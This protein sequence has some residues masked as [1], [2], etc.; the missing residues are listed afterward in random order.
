MAVRWSRWLGTLLTVPALVAACTSAPEAPA[1][2]PTPTPAVTASP[3]P[4]D[5][6]L[7]VGIVLP[8]AEARSAPEIERVREDLE[9]L[10]RTRR[11]DV[12]TWR[13]L[14][15]DGEVFVAD[16]VGFLAGDGADLVCAVGPGAREV[17]LAVAPAYP[18]TRFCAT[19]AIAPPDDVPDNV[20]LVD[21]RVE[22]AAY[23]AG[24]AAQLTS[25]SAAPAFLAG[26]T[27]HA[28]DRQRAAFQAGVDAVASEPVV[29]NVALAV[30]DAD[31]AAELA[32][33]QFV[34]G[35]TVYADTGAADEGVRR[36]AG[37]HGGLTVGWRPTLVPDAPPAPPMA[38]LLT[39]ATRFDVAVGIAVER[40]VGDWEGGLASVGLAEEAIVP[41]PGGSARYPAIAARLE[42]LRARIVSGELRPLGGG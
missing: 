39:F 7:D 27:R 22:E 34:A 8:P 36:A 37:E 18:R 17:V 40:A 11:R 13:L 19:P 4:S 12:A 21:V 30:G 28:V 1:P 33:R 20:L 32:G 31:R 42:D 24:V 41:A 35:G 9:R 29:A 3:A 23:L 16:L 14:A 15:P 25:T 10:H 6:R 26:P 5:H 38:V 2:S